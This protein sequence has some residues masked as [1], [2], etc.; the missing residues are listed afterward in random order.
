MKTARHVRRHGHTG[1]HQ[2]DLGQSRSK[3][4]GGGIHQRRVERAGHVERH[5]TQPL[6]LANLDRTLARG[7][8]AG[9]HHLPGRVEIRTDQHV[10]LAGLVANSR[11]SGLIGSDQSHH[12]GG[13][14]LSSRLHRLATQPHQANR[15]GKRERSGRAKG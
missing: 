10:P 7:D 6:G 2:L 9:N 13:R 12:S 8:R 15:I 11:G 4:L 1:N 3:L 14:G 5:A